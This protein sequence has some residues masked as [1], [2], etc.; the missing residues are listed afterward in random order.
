MLRITLE[1]PGKHHRGR[2][3]RLFRV[4]TARRALRLTSK[5]S[6]ATRTGNHTPRSSYFERDSPKEADPT[7]PARDRGRGKRSA[8]PLGDGSR[9]CLLHTPTWLHGDRPLRP[10]DGHGQRAA[11]LADSSRST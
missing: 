6:L 7:A 4:S 11:V 2:Q 8:R 10:Y 1:L 9:C 3:F 5:T